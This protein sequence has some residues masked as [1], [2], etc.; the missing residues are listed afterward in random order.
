MEVLLGWL[1]EQAPLIVV[2]GVVIYW[3]QSRLKESEK[4]KKELAK[5]VNELIGLWERNTQKMN[6]DT[7]DDS[8]TKQKILSMLT[9]IK[10]I[11]NTFIQHNTK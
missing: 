9:E 3:L 10:T 7:K 2:L 1:V 4:E 5:D 6:D 11:L 8:T